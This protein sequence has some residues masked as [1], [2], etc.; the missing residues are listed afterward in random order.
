MVFFCALRI[1]STSSLVFA[2]AYA[3]RA[4]LMAANTCWWIGS[5]PLS[6]ASSRLF[7][8]AACWWATFSS[9]D[10]RFAIRSA[11][12][13]PSVGATIFVFR[14]EL[15]AASIAGAAAAG[16]AGGGAG[17]DAG[18]VRRLGA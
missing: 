6:Y 7:S 14:G 13:R 16:A 11:S 15:S 9:W 4:F 2:L 1:F 17:G 10:L 5:L 3:S 18:G 8:A 12:D